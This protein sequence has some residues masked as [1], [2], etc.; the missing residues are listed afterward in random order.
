MP[1]EAAGAAA[2]FARRLQ[3][4]RVLRLAVGTSLSLWFA[5]A[6]AWDLAFIAPIFT[7]LL[8]ARPVPPPPFGK[9]IAL[10]LALVLPI[11]IGSVVLIPFFVHLHSVA[12]LLVM[13]ALFHSFYL[14]AKSGGA[15]LGTLLTVGISVVVAIGSVNTDAL[16]MITQA[17][18]TGAASGLIFVW[19]AHALLPDIRPPAAAGAARAAKR[20][21][22]AKPSTTEAIRLSLRAWVVVLPIAIIFLFSSASMSY[23]VVMIKVATMGTQSQAVDARNMGL[24]LIEST[25]W[26]GAGAIVIWQLL[27]LWP[28]LFFYTLLVAIAGLLVGQRI[29]NGAGM[30]PKAAM[31]SYAFLTMIVVVGPA[32]LDLANGA[33]AGPAFWTRLMLILLTAVYGSAAIVVFEAFWPARR[34]AQAPGTSQAD[35]GSFM[36]R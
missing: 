28:S 11:I 19:I 4:R 23:L 17:L 31:W 36:A 33:A 34:A 5:E 16:S 22:P 10:V 18:A 21:P 25:L 35:S 7:M 12:I 29:F 14:T 27:S 20:P 2:E 15:M 26:G 30:H 8:L 13:L 6:Q 32:L 1:T 3:T 9:G 24:S